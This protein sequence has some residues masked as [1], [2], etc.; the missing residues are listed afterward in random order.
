MNETAQIVQTSSQL[1]AIIPIT[2]PRSQMMEVMGP[3][4]HEAMAAAQE[5]GI[6]PAGAWFAHHLRIEPEIF[7]FEICVPVTAPV[8]PTGRVLASEWPAMKVIRTVYHGPYEGLGDAWGEF[9]GW[10]ESQGLKTTEDLWERY[11]VGPEVGPDGE[12]Y[13]TELNRQLAE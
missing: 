7:D 8:K 9:M 2:V 1:S 3:G 11:L 4:I 13:R 10:I 5:Q 6:G 12:L